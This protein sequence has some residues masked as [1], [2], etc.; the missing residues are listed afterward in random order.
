[1]LLLD[2]SD[3]SDEFDRFTE[4]ALFAGQSGGLV[5]GVLGGPLRQLLEKGFTQRSR[6]LEFVESRSHPTFGGLQ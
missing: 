6:V 5:R 2:S 4:A 3:Q 1:M